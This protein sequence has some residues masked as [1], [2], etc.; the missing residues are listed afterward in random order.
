[1]ANF[2]SMLE[3]VIAGLVNKPSKEG[4]SINLLA[5][6][7]P[8]KAQRILNLSLR[9]D[10]AIRKHIKQTVEDLLKAEPFKTDVK[11][12]AKNFQSKLNEKLLNSPA[13]LVNT[14]TETNKLKAMPNSILESIESSSDTAKEVKA[15]TAPKM[16]SKPKEKIRMLRVNEKVPNAFSDSGATMPQVKKIKQLSNPIIEK[17]NAPVDFSAKEIK[18]DGS[19]NLPSVV[20]ENVEALVQPKDQYDKKRIETESK[21]TLLK[22]NSQQNINNPAK[23]FRRTLPDLTEYNNNDQIVAFVPVDKNPRVYQCMQ[24][25]VESYSAVKNTLKAYDN[26]DQLNNDTI[27]A[28]S[29]KF[30]EIKSE[31][32]IPDNL[33]RKQYKIGD[34]VLALFFEEEDK[35]YTTVY[36]PGN[37]I[38]IENENAVVEF[39]AD[40]SEGESQQLVP[41]KYLIAVEDWMETYI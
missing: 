40:E 13:D 39:D 24:L 2:G 1:M 17:I 10:E 28:K 11:S 3:K 34:K 35:E 33:F 20:N 37:V 14:A 12:F 22:L 38:K 19:S 26:Q 36:Y 41:F 25:T 8:R 7:D 23:S 6:T 30:Y 4:S 31:V 32:V 15:D 29:I 27:A 16:V 9:E 5:T 18:P 21:R